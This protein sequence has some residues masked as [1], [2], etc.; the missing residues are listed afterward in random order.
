M[1]SSIISILPP[2]LA[3]LI[4]LITKEVNL[5]LGIGLFVG[6]AIYCSFQPVNTIT[7]AFDVLGARAYANMGV[8]IFVIFLGMIIVLMAKSNATAKYAQWANKKLKTRKQGLLATLFLGLII[9]VDD[10]FSCLT[11]GTIMKPIVDNNKTMSKEKLA[12]LIDA[13]AAPICMIAPLS[14]WSAAVS[15]SLPPESPINGFQLFVRSIPSNFYSLFCIAFIVMTIILNVDFGKMKESEDE[16]NSS[17]YSTINSKGLTDEMLSGKDGH[18]TI[19]DLL[20]PVIAIVVFSILAMLYTGEFFTSGVTLVDAF[21]NCDAVTGLVLGTFSTLLFM[22]ILYLPRKVITTKAFLDSLV[23]GF[24]YMVPSILILCLAWALGGICGADYLN[25]GG[26]VADMVNK[27]NFSFE[28][29][30]AVFFVVA[31][32]LAFST[33]TSWGTFA[34]LLPIA[35]AV[36]QNEISTLT[37]LTTGAVLGG[38]VCGDHLSPIS[39]TTILSSTASGCDHYKHFSTQLPYG[40]FIALVCFVSFVISGLMNNV[41]VGLILGVAVMLAILVVLKVR[42]KA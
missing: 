8:I 40:I 27:Y 38:S 5:S 9:F 41:Y 30:P 22:A 33:G 23:D 28:I 4:S 24:K 6:A 18:G 25:V 12:F 32:V 42:R 21:A 10:Y 26:F 11:V 14:S 3:I 1:E 34:I 2:I 19:M 31:V 15:S 7:T 37:I 16:A 29:V 13:L 20:L 17:N 36:F 39:D 35:I